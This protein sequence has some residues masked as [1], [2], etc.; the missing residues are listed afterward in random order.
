M[1]TRTSTVQNT[2]IDKMI[3]LTGLAS[4]ADAIAIG[5]TLTKTKTTQLGL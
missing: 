4:S 2:Y 1:V 3:V 5:P